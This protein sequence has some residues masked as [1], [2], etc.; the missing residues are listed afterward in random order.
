MIGDRSKCTTCMTR[1][2]TQM[3]QLNGCGYLPL[4]EGRAPWRGY[5]FVAPT[6]ADGSAIDSLVCPGYSTNL[7]ETIE[8]ARARMHW[9]KSSLRDFCGGQPDDAVIVGVEILEGADNECQAWAMD[10]P[11]KGRD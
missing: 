5:G 1:L 4:I 11:R 2:D 7:P 6:A 3:R 9:S 8:L 10:N